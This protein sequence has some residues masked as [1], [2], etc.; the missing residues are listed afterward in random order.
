MQNIIKHKKISSL[1]ILMI[2]VFVFVMSIPKRAWAPHFTSMNTL[3]SPIG[4][5]YRQ[6]GQLMAFNYFCVSPARFTLSVFNADTGSEVGSTF[7]GHIDP[8]E[9]VI[10]TFFDTPIPHARRNIV[11]EIVIECPKLIRKIKA[12]DIHPVAIEVVDSDT[13]NTIRRIEPSFEDITRSVGLG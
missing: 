6:F 2:L 7:V 12:S 3:T 1:A 8:G 5:G 11:V 4:F 13:N 10:H 9:G